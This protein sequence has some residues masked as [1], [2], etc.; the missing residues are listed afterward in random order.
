MEWDD[1]HATA[2]KEEVGMNHDVTAYIERITQEW[3]TDVCTRLRAMLYEAVP[4]IQERL[5]YGKPHYLKDGKYLFVFNAA[6]GW[7]SCTIFNAA[8]LEAPEHFFEPGDPNRRTIKLR[9]GQ[10]IDYSQLGAYVQQAAQ[11][12]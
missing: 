6:K 5:Q 11:S 4:D 3:Q 10:A 2:N 12:L 9:A 1:T 7:V 8:A